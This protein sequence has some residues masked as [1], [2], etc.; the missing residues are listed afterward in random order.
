VVDSILPKRANNPDFF[1]EQFIV[2]ASGDFIR[3]EERLLIVSAEIGLDK[4]AAQVHALGGFAIPA[5]VDRKAFS[6]LANLGFVPPG[7]E[8]LEI[9]RHLKPVEA[10]LC[11]PQIQGYPLIQ[12]GDAHRLDEFLGV[13]EFLIEAPT[14]SEIRMALKSVANRALIITS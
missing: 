3:R 10:T 4:A 5:H 1:G 11:Y 12:S 14:L 6:L 13:C 7:F 2:D 8:A 9:S